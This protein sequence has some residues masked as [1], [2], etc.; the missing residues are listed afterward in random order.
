MCEYCELTD[1]NEIN[2]K[3]FFENN[4]IR[5]QYHYNY[6]IGE[7]KAEFYPML[8]I[9]PKNGITSYA[10][11]GLPTENPIHCIICGRKLETVRLYYPNKLQMLN[12]GITNINKLK[13]KYNDFNK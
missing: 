12:C 13:E 2:L 7:F 11:K 6:F 10:F 5:C 9:T 3:P 1:I 8:D 4:A